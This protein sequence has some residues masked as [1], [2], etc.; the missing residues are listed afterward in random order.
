VRAAAI[1]SPFADLEEAVASPTSPVEKKRRPAPS[2][3]KGDG[4]R[5]KP[6]H[7]AIGGA[8]GLLLVVI[9]GLVLATRGS[10]KPDNLEIVQRTDNSPGKNPV[11]TPLP[12]PSE[13]NES[14]SITKD[15][16]EEAPLPP[17]EETAKAPDAI[18]QKYESGFPP[19]TFAKHFIDVDGDC[20]L[21]DADEKDGSLK[22]WVPQLHDLYP[23]RGM[24]APR[25]L[26]DVEGDF[27]MEARVRGTM[28]A[29]PGLEAPFIQVSYRCGCLIVW[30][31]AGN[32]IRFDRGGKT[33]ATR[34]SPY[35]KFQRFQ[36]G[37]RVAFFTPPCKDEDTTLRIQRQGNYF[38]ASWLEGDIRGELP[39]Q[40]VPWPA[41]VKFGVG[42]LNMS[43][44]PFQ[45]VFGGIKRTSVSGNERF[46][47]TSVPAAAPTA[48][49]G[50]G[51]VRH[52]GGDAPVTTASMSLDGKLLAIAG[53][54]R[55]LGLVDVKT[56]KE[57]QLAASAL[58]I[59][60]ALF[61]KNGTQVLAAAKA[62]RE[63]L[64]LYS[65]KGGM[66]KKFADTH[67]SVSWTFLAP[68]H[69]TAEVLVGGSDG[70]VYIWNMDTG[71]Q[72]TRTPVDGV[73]E[74]GAFSSDG[75]WLYAA[76]SNPKLWVNV[77]NYANKTKEAVPN[78]DAMRL[79]AFSKPLNYN[80]MAGYDNT[81][82][83]NVKI[84]L[85]HQ[86]PRS[87]T[88]HQAPIH[89]IGF[90][91]DNNMAV[92]ADETGRVSIWDVYEDKEIWRRSFPPAKTRKVA[93][94]NADRSLLISGDGVDIV[95]W[96]EGPQKEEEFSAG[97]PPG[98]KTGPADWTPASP[99]EKLFDGKTFAG[100]EGDT[101]KTWRIQEGAIAAGSAA[102]SAPQNDFVA[103]KKEYENFELRLKFKT[104]G[105]FGVNGG[106]NFRSRRKP[107]RLV[108]GYQADI[109]WD[110][111]GK[112]VHGSLFDESRRD[113]LLE[114]PT[115][116]DY[117]RAMKAMGKD[118]WHDY[119]IRAEGKRIRIWLNGVRTVD[120][121]ETDPTIER[122]GVIALQIA[123]GMKALIFYKDIEIQPLVAD[124]GKAIDVAEEANTPSPSTP[125]GLG[126]V[127]PGD[128]VEVDDKGVENLA[129]R[130]RVNE[131]TQNLLELRSG[132]GWVAYASYDAARREYR[133]FFEWQKFGPDRSP[134]GVWAD[135][136]QIRIERL[137]SG[138]L[139]VTGRSKANVLMIRAKATRYGPGPARNEIKQS[140]EP[141]PNEPGRVQPG[142][143]VQMD[144]TGVATTSL[145]IRVNGLT[146]NILELRGAAGWLAYASYDETEKCYHGFY[147]RNNGADLCQVRI[148]RQENGQF[149]IL[150]KAREKE[151][152]VHAVLKGSRWGHLNKTPTGVKE[153]DAFV[154]IEPKSWITT[155][156]SYSGPI[157]IT[158]IAR[159]VHQNIRIHAFNGSVIFNWELNPDQLRV[160][161]PDNTVATAP[162]KRLLANTWY[163]IRWRITENGM[164]IAVDG[165]LVFEEMSTYDLSK[166]YP[167]IMPGF[168]S[169]VD[170]MHLAVES[171][172]PGT[173]L[174]SAGFALPENSI[175]S[176]SFLASER[177]RGNLLRDGSF[178]TATDKAWT[179]RSVRGNSLAARSVADY[180]KHGKQ[181]LRIQSPEPDDV[182]FLQRVGIKANTRYLF[183]GWI[184]TE[185]VK[186]T[187]KDGTIGANLSIDGGYDITSSY[188][189][190]KDRTYA[191]LTFN[192]GNR[193]EVEV[194]ARLGYPGSMTTGTAWFDDLCLIELPKSNLEKKAA[195]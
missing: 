193:T 59:H 21:I 184:K 22:F 171:L 45:A 10:K 129:L 147:E 166:G 3:V 187:Q 151:V 100:W 71:R 84:N 131:L 77:V 176:P 135:L 81:L 39:A 117:D 108:A 155:K 185:D 133:G 78:K 104:V 142:D 79:V 31:D 76:G 179:V 1:A 88:G 99:K 95:D 180:Q 195:P 113:R 139:N 27:T 7:Y 136:Y 98:K 56:G 112:G 41:K 156:K 160:H 94:C 57:R 123:M 24:N 89:A 20:K 23:K 29:K 116:E 154:S 140:P 91:D 55:D 186:F 163:S 164:R 8:V 146:P 46:D 80:M 127:K 103:T 144:E 63:A 159:T 191:T 13:V 167:V 182:K 124:S 90:S 65:V 53:L 51:T 43:T 54:G 183:S 125:T 115:K 158:A 38:V 92:A 130:I 86:K 30:H 68:A 165:N 73:A 62:P 36:D 107:D 170:V 69:N 2:S 75:E 9:A 175:T 11:V 141:P 173:P 37:K 85:A 153:T 128:Y 138:Q 174:D 74:H 6:M 50:E 16:L 109:G 134:G 169:R 70:F 168:D 121:L 192:S 152:A 18:A 5:L 178:E 28:I 25:V 44:G 64:I 120:Y 105:A 122:K 143:Y 15:V 42:A 19:V 190:T 106:V 148:A 32:F 162:A 189:G 172:P 111:N 35:L 101:K 40:T 17:K 177:R 58:R 110:M 12:K 47:I 149:S 188:S 67:S 26:E 14:P 4:F 102:T 82:H 194:S 52:Y 150:G 34:Q 93:F 66:I 161:R 49:A 145:A 96:M 48:P 132:K 61:V 83:L 137:E 126:R 119:R 97:I 181:S 114:N 118:G 60:Q 33:T 87:Y 157:E 72:V